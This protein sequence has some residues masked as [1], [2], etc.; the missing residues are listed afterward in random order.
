MENTP[1]LIECPVC[2]GKV[3]SDAPACPHCGHPMRAHRSVDSLTRPIKDKIGSV[4]SAVR[5]S[6]K[7]GAEGPARSYRGFVASSLLHIF[8]LI[9]WCAVVL[10]FCAAVG[11]I[12]PA[13]FA[14]LFAVVWLFKLIPTR[15][16]YENLVAIEN[17]KANFS[18]NF[19]LDMDEVQCP[20]C[21][22]KMSVEARRCP[23][24]KFEIGKKIEEARVAAA[25]R[26]EVEP[27]PPP[28]QEPAEIEKPPVSIVI[29][30]I[31]AG[32]IFFGVLIWFKIIR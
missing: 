28:A 14:M 8:W 25:A 2:Q 22:T 3:S 23:K 19:H 32:V 5:E 21:M 18:D 31:V 24:C 4:S 1:Q 16:R 30:F 9:F 20:V 13:S 27:P 15:E 10:A 29:F 26:G 7:E 11:L 6:V 17:R 12:T